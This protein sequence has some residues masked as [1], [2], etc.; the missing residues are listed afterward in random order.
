MANRFCTS[1][2]APLEEDKKFCTECGAPAAATV[3]QNPARQPA[4]AP[5]PARA[6]APAAVQAPPPQAPPPQAAYTPADG[7]PAGL[8]APIGT[9]GWIGIFLLL[10]IPI[11][12][13][14]LLI[15]WAVGGCQKAVKRSFARA[16]LIFLVISII[17]GAAA[18]YF[19]KKAVNGFLQ[20]S[21]ITGQFGDIPEGMDALNLFGGD[22]PG[23]TNGAPASGGGMDSLTALFPD[24]VFD[25][26]ILV[27]A[28]C[29]AE[30]IEMFRAV[31]EN[32]R[33]TLLDMGYPEQEVDMVL[34][35][36]R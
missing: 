15:V 8:Y 23:L 20:E 26:Q 28:G 3:N 30:E 35:M 32:D 1:C 34:N 25:E 5:Q 14:I 17:L 12:N 7:K 2:G 4:A 9:L 33:Q 31:M 11:V 16:A 6:F 24:G 36:F 27:D 18:G 13:I 19:V 10:L 22:S 29:S 21:G